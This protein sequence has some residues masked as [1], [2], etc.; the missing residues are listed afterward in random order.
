MAPGDWTYTG[1]VVE[2]GLFMAEIEGSIIAIYLDHLAVFNM[3]REGADIDERW[4]AR[5]SAIPE[6]GTKGTITIKPFAEKMVT[7]GE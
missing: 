4:G 5:R 3:T 6:I 1:S 7:K 2:D